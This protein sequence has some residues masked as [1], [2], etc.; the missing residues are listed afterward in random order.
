LSL[1]RLLFLLLLL[2]A[3]AGVSVEHLLALNRSA[4]AAT[5][6]HQ[7]LNPLCFCCCCCCCSSLCAGLGLAALGRCICA[8]ASPAEP[9]SAAAAAAGFSLQPVR[10][11]GTGGFGEVYLCR[12]HSCDVA[13]KCVNPNLLVPDGGMGSISKVG[14][15]AD[16]CGRI[17]VCMS[18]CT[19]VI[20]LYVQSGGQL[21]CCAVVW[22][23]GEVRQPQYADA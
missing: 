17:Y 23:C 5:A 9:S 1:L 12:W 4:G 19:K 7:L 13:V 15:L 18:S 10:L 6:H 20:Q 22:C 8:A 11:L 21:L 16:P 3:A 14:V 2:Y